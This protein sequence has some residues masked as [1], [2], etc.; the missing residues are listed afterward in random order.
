MYRP[1][2]FTET[3]PGA[4]AAWAT[5][6]MRHLTR[7]HNAIA[8]EQSIEQ[9][10]FRFKPLY[11]DPARIEACMVVYFAASAPSAGGVEG[12]YRRSIAGAWVFVG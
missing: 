12:L 5:N 10:C 7:E 1:G 6:L 8:A 3:P 2:S 4:I 9:D 11:A